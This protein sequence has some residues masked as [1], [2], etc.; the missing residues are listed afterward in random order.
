MVIWIIPVA[1]LYTSAKSSHWCLWFYISTI[2][3]DIFFFFIFENEGR[4]GL[5]FNWSVHWKLVAV[6]GSQ[7]V[8][9]SVC[10]YP[11]KLPQVKF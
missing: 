3:F 8:I 10:A 1:D 6:A 11:L 2:E 4:W 9:Q 7:D 5:N